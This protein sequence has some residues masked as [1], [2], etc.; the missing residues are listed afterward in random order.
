MYAVRRI[1]NNASVYDLVSLR[2]VVGQRYLV[3]V[4]GLHISYQLRLI[5]PAI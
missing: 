4:V 5:G 3:M 2:K 1:V